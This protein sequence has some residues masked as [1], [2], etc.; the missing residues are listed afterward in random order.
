MF[1]DHIKKVSYSGRN[2][3]SELSERQNSDI[4]VRPQSYNQTGREMGKFRQGLGRLLELRKLGKDWGRLLEP[5]KSFSVVN[6]YDRI[7]KG[8]HYGRN[9]RSELIK[10]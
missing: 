9:A 1:M 7:K 8:S 5:G 10:H 3:K 4:R 6:V 2:A